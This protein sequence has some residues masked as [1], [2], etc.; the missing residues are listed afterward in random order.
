[1][2]AEKAPRMQYQNLERTGVEQDGCTVPAGARPSGP[3]TRDVGI[4]NEGNAQTEE[5]I[6]EEACRQG[7]LE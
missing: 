3:V 4:G 2:M 1:M 5:T 6:E 7:A